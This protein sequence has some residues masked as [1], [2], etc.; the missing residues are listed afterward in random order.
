MESRD[1]VD[2]IKDIVLDLQGENILILDIQGITT[3]AD[4]FFICSG[5]S[6]RHLDALYSGIRERLKRE[7]GILAQHIEGT[8]ES[9]WILMDYGGVIV[10]IFSPAMRAYYRLEDLWKNAH[11]VVSIQ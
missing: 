2:R 11:V 9:G 6:T 8:P 3:I 4:Y 5:T 10:H 7:D 1:L